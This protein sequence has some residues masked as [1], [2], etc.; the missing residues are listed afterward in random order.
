LNA[1][2]PGPEITQCAHRP[3]S[4]FHE[5]A[6]TKAENSMAISEATRADSAASSV[7][8]SDYGKA[9]WRALLLLVAVG[10]FNFVDRQLP[11][12]LAEPI[13]RDLNL[14]DTMLGLVNGVAFLLVYALIGVPIARIAD[15][16]AYGLVV[17]L[18]LGFW[19]IM[20]SLGGLAQTGWQLALT[21]IGV[22]AGE[23]GSTPAAHA[24][25]SSRFPPDRRARAFGV[26]S[27]MAPLGA[28]VGLVGGGFLAES[29]GWRGT[30]LVIGGCGLVLTPLVVLALRGP[31]RVEEPA[32]K[33]GDLR[34]GL[35]LLRKRAFLAIVIGAGLLAVASY[36][37]YGFGP[38]FLMRSHG[39]SVSEVGVG[40]GV[41]KG[42]IG[43]IALLIAGTL[44]DKLAARDPRWLVWLVVIIAAISAPL[45]IAA[46]LASDGM[47][48]AVLVAAASAVSAAYLAPVIAALHRLCPQEFRATA[49]AVLL[50]STGLLGA[51]GPLLIGVISDA[52]KASYGV[53]SLGRALWIVPVFYA[54]AAAVFALASRRYCEEIVE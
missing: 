16:G 39:M 46:W 42:V 48:A 22:A 36:A 27:T 19:S 2:G 54:L 24:F 15:R 52:L 26:L 4:G 1:D 45:S 31:R 17:G 7:P 34:T 5:R 53:H 41:A 8:A 12:L 25:I 6:S 9:P 40:L 3:N 37:I 50:L 10:I 20:T 38:A 43:L 33:A 47:V 13:K 32:H 51:L 28:M 18:S 49:S 29:L 44:A 14:S 11:Y 35:N 23:S 21:R 30:F